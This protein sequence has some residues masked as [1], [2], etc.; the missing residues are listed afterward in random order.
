MSEVLWKPAVVVAGTVLAAYLL[1]ELRSLILPLTVSG[2]L[3]YICRPLVTGLERLH[4]PRGLAIGLVVTGFLSACLIIIVAIQAVVPSE[5]KFIELKVHALYAVNER[6]KVLMGLDHSPT[7]GNRLYRVVRTDVN[8]MMDQ[9]HQVLAL[10]PEEHAEFLA[11]HGEAAGVKPESDALLNEHQANLMT[12]KLPGRTLSSDT[13][14]A[15]RAEQTFDQGWTK[16]M[17]TPLTALGEVLSSWIIAPLVF[18]FLL[19]DTGE[20]KRGLLTL[21]PNRLFEPALAILSDLDRAVGNYLRGIS[22][23][24]SLLGATITVFFFLI[25]VPLRWALAIGLFA[26]L[27]NVVPYL[28]SVVAALAGLAYAFIGEEFRPLL[29]IVERD[30]LAVWVVAAVLLA[31]IIKNAVYDPVVLGGAVRLHPLVVIIGFV[32]GTVMF[33][34]VGAI[35]AIPTIT[36]F[37]VFISSTARH[38]KAYGLV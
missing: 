10:T 22:L 35:L 11:S 26:G 18:F 2:L 24:C 3:A 28:G 37:T 1:W 27:T 38:L 19:R 12:R 20:I 13:G 21:V 30:S 34:F 14:A 32:S 4:V 23:S 36:V 15:G 8:A 33:G 29:L 16:F 25:G 7:S 31:D 5:Q 9:L 17:R 6:Y